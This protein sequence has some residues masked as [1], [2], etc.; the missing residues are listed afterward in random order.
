MEFIAT[1]NA[2]KTTE[3]P[4]TKNTEFKKMLL[5]LIVIR[6]FSFLISVNVVPEIYAKNAG[7]MGKIHG[8]KNDPI[9]AKNAILIE[10]SSTL[11]LYRDFI[12][13]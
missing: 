8:A 1:P 9:P 11:M 5:L 10:T 6:S 2:E 3:N 7:I 12:K 4:R 13:S